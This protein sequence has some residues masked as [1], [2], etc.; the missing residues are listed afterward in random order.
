MRLSF[1]QSSKNSV[2]LPGK[3]KGSTKN[4]YK[5][6]QTNGKRITRYP[7]CLRHIIRKPLSRQ[8]IPKGSPDT[9]LKGEKILRKIICLEEL[10][11][12]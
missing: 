10:K 6:N 4:C 1:K 12:H 8:K 7:Q 5:D 2:I 9:E 3:N 11:L